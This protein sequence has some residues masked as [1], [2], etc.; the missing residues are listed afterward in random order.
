MKNNVINLARQDIAEM[1]AYRS[2]RS[3][4]LQ[5]NV[6][7]DANEN[8]ICDTRYNRYRKQQPDQLAVL[9]AELYNIDRKRMLITRGSDE[10]IDLLIRLFCHARLDKIIICPPTYG[11]YKVAATIQGADTIEVPLSKDN[12]FTLDI[13]AI[14][15]AWNP[16]VKLIFLCSPNNPTGNVLSKVDILSLCASLREKAIIV[17]DEAYIEFA[18]DESLTRY[19]NQYP[20]LVILRTLSK[21]YGLAG[22]RCGATIANSEI[23][24]LLTKIIAPYPIPEPVAEIVCQALNR[25]IARS[26][27]MV[28]R[29]EKEK[30]ELFL[31]T[32]PSI[33]KVWKSHANYLLIETAGADMMMNA[34]LRNGIVLRNRSNEYGLNNCIRITIGSPGEN[35]LLREVLRNV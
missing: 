9:L 10:G 22:V 21:A 34:C 7:L 31:Q 19:I 20:N 1:K 4:T 18:D 27:I 17:V 25:E 15:R 16:R 26:S 24:D 2:A 29:Q 14:L 6:Y 3:E 23:I 12:G 33:K 32:L 30:M 5:G 28:I 13:D 35:K 8:A 11:M